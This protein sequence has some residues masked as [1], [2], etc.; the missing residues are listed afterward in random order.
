MSVIK[1]RG[2]VLKEIENGENSKQIV[3]LA[4]GIGK[5]LLSARGARKPKSKFLAGTQLFCCCDFLVYEGRGFYSITQIDL[6][7]SFYD[8]RT[9]V[10]K[11]AHCIYLLE[12]LER[13]CLAGMEQDETLE[14]LF[15]TLR[16]MEHKDANPRLLARIFEL[17]YLQIFGLMPEM[18]GCTV[19]GEELGEKAYFSAQ[20]GNMAC[21]RHRIGTMSEV[22]AGARKAMLYVF[23]H[24]I[25][26]IF[27]FRVSEGVQKELDGIL[28]EYMA[29]HMNLELKTRSFAEN[30]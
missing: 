24:E 15:R 16:M 21:E 22:S 7:E 17:K 18:E 23:E 2:I 29:I 30:L 10:E 19:C 3:V 6:I 11:L 12:L 13:T 8:L 20:A 1:I 5:V 14:L 4:K 26:H 9:D 27:G 25:R 28:R